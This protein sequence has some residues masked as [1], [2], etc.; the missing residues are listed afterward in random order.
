MW[1][2]ENIRILENLSSNPKLFW[3]HIKK[4]RGR[5]NNS[6][7]KVDS[8]PPKKWA[9]H[10]FSLFNVK[11]SDKNKLEGSNKIHPPPPLMRNMTLFLISCL[12]QRKFQKELGN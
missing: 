10:F 11:E 9:E 2:I 5:T 1:D 3:Q 4:L 7:N 12:Q 8:I 6:P